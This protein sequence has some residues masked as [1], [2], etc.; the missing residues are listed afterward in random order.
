MKKIILVS[1]LILS[2][3]QN[4]QSKITI[5]N[6][7]DDRV[8]LLTKKY[9]EQTS[10]KLSDFEKRTK[11]QIVILC[12]DSIGENDFDSF[13][14][15]IANQ[16]GIGE[17]Y[18]NNGLLIFLSKS[19]YKIRINVGSGLEW[20]ISDKLAKGIV[21]EMIPLLREGNY[22]TALDLALN[23]IIPL[24]ESVSWQIS[25]KSINE[26]TNSDLGRI[27]QFK[28]IKI[29]E[30]KVENLDY[31]NQSEDNLVL[32]SDSGKIINLY[33]TIYRYHSY[34]IDDKKERLIT[35]RLIKLNPLTFQLLGVER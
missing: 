28:G 35:A 2:C 1:L 4:V 23:R 25:S 24:A 12:I 26:I 30:E 31:E 17:K 13:V 8:N 21:D 3:S 11:V 20:I 6:Y 10:K 7:V 22:E 29:R 34:F 19:D 9:I 16:N 15:D 14:N 5:D 18:V 33:V 27:F 32:K